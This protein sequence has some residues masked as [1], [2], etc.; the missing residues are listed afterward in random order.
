MKLPIFETFYSIQGEG[1]NT[2]MPA[3]FV[4]LAGCN[5]G[6]TFCDEKK[7]W[8]IDNSQLLGIDEIVSRIISCKS[9][10]VVITGGEPTIYDLTELTEKLQK[11]GLKTFLETSGVNEIKGQFSH[12]TLSPKQNK[13]PL[14]KRDKDS[15][16]DIFAY[17]IDSLKVVISSDLDFSFAEQMKNYVRQEEKVSFYLQPEW[18]KKETIIPIIIEYIKQNPE[19][20]LSLQMHKYINVK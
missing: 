3:C 10:N 18:D 17:H 15:G 20:N 7:A 16:K 13:L 1:E 14:L 9:P 11:L 2:G 12:I 4:R 8:N 19:W 5:V 6:C